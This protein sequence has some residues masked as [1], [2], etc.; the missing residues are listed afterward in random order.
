MT[1]RYRIVFFV[2]VFFFF[3]I[4]TKLFYWQVVKADELSAW[5]LSQYGQQNTLSPERGEIQTSDGFPIA[6]NRLSY[7]VFANPKEISASEKEKVSLLLSSILSIDQA[8]ISAKLSKNLY[9]VPIKSN[10]TIS[11]KDQIDT[12]HVAGVGFEKQD[13][14]FD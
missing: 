6:T 8:T 13:A 7:L 9:W 3:V 12:L 2:I 11:Q 4:V 5:G 10:V 14:R 1:W